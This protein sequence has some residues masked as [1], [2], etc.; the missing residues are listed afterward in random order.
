MKYLPQ[1]SQN[2][3]QL[4]SNKNYSTIGQENQN[5]NSENWENW[6]SGFKMEHGNNCFNWLL[7]IF[8]INSQNHINP[9]KYKQEKEEI[10]ALQNAIKNPK[11]ILE[12]FWD[13]YNHI[14]NLQSKN[15]KLEAKN[16]SLNNNN[17]AWSQNNNFLITEN[18]ELKNKVYK[19]E[20]EN[21]NKVIQL[22]T[23]IDKLE[24]EN[25]E[26]RESKSSLL[27]K[28]STRDRDKSSTITS[29]D[30]R[31][32]RDVLTQEFTQLNTQEITDIG[33]KIFNHLSKTNSDLKPHRKREIAKIKSVFSQH[34]F[35]KG[36]Q[37][38]TADNF[39]E[40]DNFP[41]VVENFTN[42]ILTDLQIPETAKI[43]EPIPTNLK[44]LVEKGL[45][46]VK[47]IVN[48]DPPGHFLIANQG[49]AFNSEKHQ[50]VAGCEPNGKIIYT[51]Y[52]GYCVNDRIIGE[53][54]K[55]FVFTEPEEEVSPE[56]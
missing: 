35:D 47:E 3:N 5:D 19:L 44:N 46:L 51:T 10:N 42:S 39:I 37:C 25:Q 45:N 52:P 21:Q 30:S 24:K 8:R 56:S 15:E 1:G 40:K 23:R 7:Q 6:L 28:L 32:Q 13:I 36:S 50:P 27:S 33:N 54:L 53:S 31:R 16:R 17:Y 20:Q 48:D 4:Y 2:Q 9:T 43:P 49:D 55:A 22:Q 41:Q 11:T 14:V 29:N 12:T 34:I 38:F 18:Q 26:L